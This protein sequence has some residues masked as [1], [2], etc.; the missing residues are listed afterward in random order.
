M[1]FYLD[2]DYIE[3]FDS[4]TITF[5]GKF[6]ESSGIKSYTAMCYLYGYHKKQNKYYIGIHKYKFLSEIIHN[7][8]YKNY[9]IECIIEY[10]KKYIYGFISNE[11]ELP[12]SQEHKTGWELGLVAIELDEDIFQL[13]NKNNTV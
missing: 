10:N 1:S 9:N 3:K 12:S 13:N 5:L 6:G 2:V 7:I 11:S 8:K 4:I